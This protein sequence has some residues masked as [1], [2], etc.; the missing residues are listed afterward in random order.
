[1]QRECSPHT[2]CFPLM[3]KINK[4]VFAAPSSLQEL[5]I[6][7]VATLAADFHSS[8]IRL[9][10]LLRVLLVGFLDETVIERAR[11]YLRT[12]NLRHRPF[13]IF[14]TS[15][16]LYLLIHSTS[17]SISRIRFDAWKVCEPHREPM[18]DLPNRSKILVESNA[19][20][21]AVIDFVITTR[22]RQRLERDG[23]EASEA[24][25]QSNYSVRGSSGVET[26]TPVT[27]SSAFRRPETFNR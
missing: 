13:R 12:D 7:Y 5:G 18:N 6:E 23:T 27:L 21:N 17:V 9:L 15:D 3:R 4:V 22:Q 10:H 11:L 1:M 19:Q 26:F 24:A 8:G 2:G 14:L 16:E 20:T 25:F